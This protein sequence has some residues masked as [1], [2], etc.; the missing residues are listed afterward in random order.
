MTQV[1]EDLRRT[2]EILETHGWCQG[3]FAN[4]DG[5]VCL[6]GAV[7]L[8]TDA[9]VMNP[10]KWGINFLDEATLDRYIA[11]WKA[12]EGDGEFHEGTGWAWNDA[13]GRT[14]EDVKQ[15]LIRAI[16]RAEGE[17]DRG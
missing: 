11:V 8:A 13:Q 7:Y 2:K 16:A 17:E 15:L 14:A 6:D 5:Q 9:A 10:S 4:P 12:L 1:L 3:A